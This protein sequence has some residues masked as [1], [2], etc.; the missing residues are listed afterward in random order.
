MPASN[1]GYWE[2]KLTG[3]VLRDRATDA[4]L[5]AEGWTVL[6][7]WEHEDPAKTAQRIAS[8]VRAAQPP[9]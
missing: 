9:G 5:R 4:A 6:C 8:A 2:P 3:N 7:A 1:R